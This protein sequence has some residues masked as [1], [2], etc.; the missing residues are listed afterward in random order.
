MFSSSN[1]DGRGCAY[2]HKQQ[3]PASGQSEDGERRQDFR[4][5]PLDCPS[6]RE[7]WITEDE[8]FN[9]WGLVSDVAYR[10]GAWISQTSTALPE[11]MQ[12][13]SNR[14]CQ[15]A[16]REGANMSNWSQRSFATEVA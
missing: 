13:V 5:V 6:P 10:K 16:K 1:H 14:D 7:I 3:R 15:D 4:H 2:Y 12:F 11:E 8:D 9:G